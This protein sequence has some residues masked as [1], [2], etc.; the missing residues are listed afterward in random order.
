MY[1]LSG[2]VLSLAN[3]PRFEEIWPLSTFD[4]NKILNKL[5]AKKQKNI[6]K[7][8]LRNFTNREKQQIILSS[9]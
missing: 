6:D 7:S 8:R 2:D 5:W 1:V 9:A 4:V 3:I